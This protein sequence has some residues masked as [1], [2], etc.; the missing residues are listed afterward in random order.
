MAKRRD[1]DTILRTMFSKRP[2]TRS[3]KIKQVD[4]KGKEKETT[5]NVVITGKSI[6][7]FR[8]E[9]GN[10]YNCFISPYEMYFDKTNSHGQKDDK[11]LT[12]MTKSVEK[13]L[14]DAAENNNYRIEIDRK[15]VSEYYKEHKH[16][17]NNGSPKP[18]V[19]QTEK[20]NI[21]V[22]PDYLLNILDWCRSDFVNVNPHQLSYGI[23]YTWSEDWNNMAMVLPCRI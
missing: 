5:V 1:L 10:T 6:V 3:R 11:D 20:G 4:N 15:A 19:I 14:N 22:N 7:H 13:I 18:Y 2:V 16:Y 8:N 12:E 17:G 23:I 9:D 21:G